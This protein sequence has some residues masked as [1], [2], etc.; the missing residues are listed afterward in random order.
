MLS[1][2]QDE[3]TLE[4]GKLVLAARMQD[5]E[6]HQIGI[7]EK[8]LLGFGARGG[9]YPGKLAKVLVECESAQVV[10]ADSREPD[11]LVLGKELLAGLDPNHSCRLPN[12]SMLKRD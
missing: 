4:A 11:H 8:P 12:R 6:D 1:R 5:R 7:R 10:Q 9:G 2:I 3:R